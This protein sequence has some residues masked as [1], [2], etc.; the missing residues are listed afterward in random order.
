[1]IYLGDTI[2]LSA[3]QYAYPTIQPLRYILIIL[4]STSTNTFE[5]ENVGNPMH[6][7]GYESFEQ[8]LAANRLKVKAVIFIIFGRF[9]LAKGMI[10]LIISQLIS[11]TLDFYLII[12]LKSYFIVIIKYKFIRLNINQNIHFRSALGRYGLF[13]YTC[14]DGDFY[15]GIVTF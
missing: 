9:L 10:F 15:F 11:L 4:G 2:N 12:K 5:C 14:L 13:L 1:M 7:I 3:K 6:F 8:F